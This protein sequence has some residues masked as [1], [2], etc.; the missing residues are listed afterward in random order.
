M[1]KVPIRNYYLNFIKKEIQNYDDI[2]RDHVCDFAESIIDFIM[3]YDDIKSLK[4]IDYSMIKNIVESDDIKNI[5]YTLHL[6]A[7]KPHDVL[8]WVFYVEDSDNYYEPSR[9]YLTPK[10]IAKTIE[11]KDFYNPITGKSV[12]QEKFSELVN[13]VFQVSDNFIEKASENN[14]EGSLQ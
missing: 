13:T 10:E 1:N 14:V 6:L 5:Q 8:N 3:D 7:L 2:T 11:E 12:T 4:E 9:V